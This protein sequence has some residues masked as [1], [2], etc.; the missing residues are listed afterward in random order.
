MNVA[1]I[2]ELIVRFLILL[3]VN[4]FHGKKKRDAKRRGHLKKLELTFICLSFFIFSLFLACKS[5]SAGTAGLSL[6][7]NDGFE[8]R[9][10][11][12]LPRGWRIIPDYMGKGDA[13]M[14]GT[15]HT[16][17]FSM[18]IKPNE[19]NTKGGFG[20]FIMLNRDEVKGKEITVSGFVRVEDIG[21]NTAGILLKTDKE[22][23]LVLPKDTGGK[24]VPFSKTF[25]ISPSI[26]NAALLLLISGTKGN[27]WFDELS[28]KERRESRGDI[29]IGSLPPQ[30]AILF[31][32]NRDTGRRRREIYSMDVNGKNV[33]RIT[34]TNE[35]H[36]ILGMD[37]LRRYIVASRAEKDTKKPSGL[38]DEDRRSLWLIDLKTK[39]ENRLTDPRNHAEGDSFSPDGVWI[40]FH[41]KIAGEEQSD[42]Y[43]IRRD[44]SNL[45]RLTNTPSAVEADPNWSNDGTEIVFTYLDAHS[46]RFL[47]KKMDGRGE[48]ITTIYDGGAGVSA[49]A[50]PP[51]NYDPSWS[52]DD[53]WI[54]FERAVKSGSE[55]WG[56][57]IW[58]IFKVR[59]NGSDVADIS[60]AGGHD[61]RAEYLPS[62]SPDGKFIVFGTLYEA[63]NPHDSL[64]DVFIMDTTGKG[65]KRLT[66]DPA[67][68]KDMYPVWIP[69]G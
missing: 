24:F 46:K 9:G 4:T 7:D 35:H 48:N 17:N 19:R 69:S 42:I 31:V 10:N 40:V 27:V 8:E 14:D 63:K 60:V 45:T 68:D 41:M 29:R 43:K 65:L 64:N 53:Q 44:G 11:E 38:G 5:N 50:F 23:W 32:S 28:V 6:F 18:R 54:V 13:Y 47:L 57:G 61:D 16:G 3:I 12:N 26:P 1:A 39:Q 33:T 15:A 34:F 36:F 20:V 67:S 49:G 58:H 56:S 66:L 55:N 52:P 2:F 37:R 21:D 30:A 59:R 22:N 25:S 62:Y 51:G